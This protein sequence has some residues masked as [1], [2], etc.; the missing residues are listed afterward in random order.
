MEKPLV[1]FESLGDVGV[2]T[3]ANPEK[4]NVMSRAAM[5]QVIERMQEAEATGG[6]KCVILAAEGPAFSAGHD[7]AEIVAA[8]DLER[9]SL[10]AL[11]TQMMTTIRELSLPVIA[12][13]QGIATAAGCQLAATC[14]LIV[15]AEEASFATPGIK[16]GLFCST[17]AVAVSRV[18]GPKKT[19]E[20]LLTAEPVSAREAERIGLVN[21]VVPPDKLAEATLALAQKIAAASGHTIELGKRA[22][23]EQLELDVPLAYQVTERIMVENAKSPDAI[24]GMKAF[25]EKRPPQWGG[26]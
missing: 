20:M 2:V 5:R 15:A 23:Y 12:Q 9:E 1:T 13:V 4:R 16:I 18:I 3:L 8:S 10:F 19:M 22:F 21:R 11:C 25:L 24:E 17:P 6:V 7:L 26:Q 14:D